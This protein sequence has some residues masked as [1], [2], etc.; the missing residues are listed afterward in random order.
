M[1]GGIFDESGFGREFWGAPIEE[2]SLVGASRHAHAA[3]NAAALVNEDNALFGVVSCCYRA[4][5]N[6]GSILTVL[7]RNRHKIGAATGEVYFIDL[8]PLLPLGDEMPLNAGLS[9]L[10]RR[11]NGN[12]PL[13]L[14]QVNHHA[15]GT[16]FL[17]G[18]YCSRGV[19]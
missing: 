8:N 3:A 18:R 17:L 5:V 11:V 13:T 4:D 10:G 14:L 19:V 9:A 1:L 6:A 2:T 7:A 16:N 15:P 12:T